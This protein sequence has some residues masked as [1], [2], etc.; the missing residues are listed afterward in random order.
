MQGVRRVL[1]GA[2]VIAVAG[3]MVVLPSFGAMAT[4]SPGWSAGGVT[5]GAIVVNQ[6][7][8]AITY[9]TGFYT[10]TNPATPSGT[11]TKIGTITPTTTAG[12]SLVI[13]SSL[14]PESSAIVTNIYTGKVVECTTTLTTQGVP[15]G[16][17]IVEGTAQ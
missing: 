13:N 9:C 14:V 7:T 4:I 3:V 8:G 1:A 17:C 11:C 10:G 5:G 15:N 16:S 12:P 2:K 6:N